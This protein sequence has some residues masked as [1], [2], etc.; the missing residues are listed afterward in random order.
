MR[1]SHPSAQPGAGGLGLG[2]DPGSSGA[3]LELL[4]IVG[5][6]DL[7][8]ARLYEGHINAL[9]LVQQF[10][11]SDQI[12]HVARDAGR[13]L[14]FG[15]WNTE[16]AD[17]LRLT[18]SDNGFRLEGGKTFASGAGSIERPLVTARDDSGGWQMLLLEM[19]RTPSSV[20]R[21]SWRTFGMRASQSF[22]IDLSGARIENHQLIGRDG[23][24]YRQPWF[25][26]G[27]VRFCAAQL[28]GAAALLDLAR[29]ELLA[30]GRAGDPLQRERIGIASSAIASGFA[31][32]DTAASLADRSQFCGGPCIEDESFITYVGLTRTTI[33]RL[34][35]ETMELVEQSLG[36]D[37]LMATHPAARIAADLRLYLRQPA[38]DATLLGAAETVLT[39]PEPFMRM[40]RDLEIHAP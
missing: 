32:L 37:S 27:A 12:E 17:G 25:S 38:P 11:A 13:G 20:D 24:Y 35:L 2:R 18:K 31:M 19:E 30:R 15:V 28:G 36:A 39:S 8:L 6:G 21:D 4:S 23:D 22:A 34:C 1:I 9:L 3:L 33:E 26:G 7:S 10:G 5:W 16:G 14:V 40:W 29:E